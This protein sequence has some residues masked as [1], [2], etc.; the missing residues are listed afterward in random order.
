[1]IAVAR[2]A[3]GTGVLRLVNVALAGNDGDSVDPDPDRVTVIQSGP[4]S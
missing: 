4:G 1:M 3:P 2:L